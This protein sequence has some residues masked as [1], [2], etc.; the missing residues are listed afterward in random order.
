[1]CA[2]VYIIAYSGDKFMPW[3][4]CIDISMTCMMLNPCHGINR[5][6]KSMILYITY[7][8]YYIYNCMRVHTH[9][10]DT[11]IIHALYYVLCMYYS[12]MHSY[13]HLYLW[14]YIHVC[15][16]IYICIYTN[17]Y[18]HRGV[19]E[20][21]NVALYKC[22]HTLLEMMSICMYTTTTSIHTYECTHMY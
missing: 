21:L 6:C 3:S 5:Q 14:V 12:Q 16:F 18:T 10:M 7:I 13:L 22:V 11:F 17:T 8:I 4:S 9:S 1:M 2:C 15:M 19:Y 20:L